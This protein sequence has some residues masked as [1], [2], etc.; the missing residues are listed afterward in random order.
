MLRPTPTTTLV[1]SGPPP[2]DYHLEDARLDIPDPSTAVFKAKLVRPV[3]SHVWARAWVWTE[4]DGTLAEAASAKMNAGDEVTLTVRLT[5]DV[6]PEAAS[7]RIES[8]PL[9]T[10]HVVRTKLP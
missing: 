10:K 8:A 7:M 6:T 5:R 3:G 1:A 2:G 9:Q 4:A